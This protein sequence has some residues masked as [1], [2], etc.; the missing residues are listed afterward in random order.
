M[1]ER[2]GRWTLGN[3]AGARQGSVLCSR[4]SGD[5]VKL[6]S[7]FC[8]RCKRPSLASICFGASCCRQK[9]WTS[10]GRAARQVQWCRFPCLALNLMERRPGGHGARCQARP[11]GKRMG[12]GCEWPSASATLPGLPGQQSIRCPDVFPAVQRG[13]Q[14]SSYCR[15]GSRGGQSWE[16]GRSLLS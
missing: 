10:T 1:L 15:Q 13:R 2:S 6:S 5:G 7:L 4:V 16:V 8:V 9:A 3:D 12:C 14:G 11:G